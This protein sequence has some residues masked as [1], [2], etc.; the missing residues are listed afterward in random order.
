MHYVAIGQC[1]DLTTFVDFF[2]SFANMSNIKSI[3]PS[4][5]IDGKAIDVTYEGTL[6]RNPPI[7][8]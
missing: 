3:A 5:K 7:D 4:I 2:S 8:T 6:D 1:F